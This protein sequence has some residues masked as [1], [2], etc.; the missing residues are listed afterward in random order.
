MCVQIFRVEYN[1]TLP[2]GMRTKK[3]GTHGESFAVHIH[4]TTRSTPLQQPN[5]FSGGLKTIRLSQKRRAILMASH[6]SSNTPK[7]A[8]SASPPTTPP[9]DK[10]GSLASETSQRPLDASGERVTQPHPRGSASAS[11]ETASIK[12]SHGMNNMIMKVILSS[13]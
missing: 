6:T 11:K 12:L 3:E 1:I 8:V 4:A 5:T 9:S 13:P 2:R 10:E 7:Q